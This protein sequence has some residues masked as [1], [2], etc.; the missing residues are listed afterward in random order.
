MPESIVLPWAGLA[1]II[2]AVVQAGMLLQRIRASEARVK[3]LEAQVRSLELWQQ[4]Q[5]GRQD[6]QAP[7]VLQSSQVHGQSPEL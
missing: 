2:A 3:T 7:H 4:R 1:S 6:A 5:R